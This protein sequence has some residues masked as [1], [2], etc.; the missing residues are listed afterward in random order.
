MMYFRKRMKKCSKIVN[1]E[2]DALLAIN[3]CPICG[4]KLSDEDE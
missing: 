3:Y 2:G 4:R 1:N